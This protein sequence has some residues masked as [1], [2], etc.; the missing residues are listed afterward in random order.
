MKI[1]V[2]LLT[3]LLTLWADAPEEAAKKAYL[4]NIN[5]VV[6]FTAK[7]GL[8][9]GYYDFTRKNTSMFVLHVA[10]R[11]HFAPYRPN[12]N[13]FVAGGAGYS[14]AWMTSAV[15]AEPY[16]DENI[17]LTATNILQS[18]VGA[19]GT[20]VRYDAGAGWSVLGGLDLIYSRVR[21]VSRGDDDGIV[22]DFFKNNYNDNLTYRIYGRVEYDRE[23]KGYRPYVI[24]HYALYETKSA[25]SFEQLSRFTSQ[26]GELSFALGAESPALLHDGPRYLTLE[27]YLRGSWIGGDLPKVVNFDAYG[28][29]GASAYWYIPDRLEYI[30]RV[31]MD[32][33]TIQADGLRG[34][35]LGIGVSLTY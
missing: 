18:Y 31:Y 12:W 25:F 27:G 8:N 10:D 23:W 26:S 3:T 24:V 21:I 15:E 11:Y 28:T 30:R 35:N 7:E 22:E 20:G 14:E 2:F 34:Y 5:A 6:V 9:S 29:V 13:L 32:I 4:A 19:L 17:T 1:L 16:L 33:S